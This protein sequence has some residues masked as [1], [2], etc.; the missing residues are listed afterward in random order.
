MSDRMETVWEVGNAWTYTGM[1]IAIVTVW[2]GWLAIPVAFALPLPGML[3]RA[4]GTDP[5]LQTDSEHTR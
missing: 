5:Y 1:V 4:I 3:M 2:L